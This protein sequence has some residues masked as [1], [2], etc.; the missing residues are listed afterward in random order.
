MHSFLQIAL[1][2]YR[3]LL[4]RKV[5]PGRHLLF[6]PHI[7]SL[8]KAERGIEMC[9]LSYCTKAVHTVVNVLDI[10]CLDCEALKIVLIIFSAVPQPHTALKSENQ[11]TFDTF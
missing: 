6:F 5:A 1:P 3:S 7:L 4:D 10:E 9:L 11:K 2:L 8:G